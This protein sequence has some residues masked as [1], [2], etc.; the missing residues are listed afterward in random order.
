MICSKGDR[1]YNLCGFQS[2]LCFIYFSVSE[3][4]SVCRV[5]RGLKVGAY[6]P[7]K[8]LTY[9]GMHALIRNQRIYSIT[10]HVPEVSEPLN[11]NIL[12]LRGTG[13]LGFHKYFEFKAQREAIKNQTKQSESRHAHSPLHIKVKVGIIH[14]LR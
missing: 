9:L 14:H 10:I 6:L 2:I 3:C 5:I 7:N 1:L 12:P 11:Y 8:G 4:S 13:K